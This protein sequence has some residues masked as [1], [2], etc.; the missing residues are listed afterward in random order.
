MLDESCI[1]LSLKQVDSVAHRIKREELHEVLAKKN[2][3]QSIVLSVYEVEEGRLRTTQKYIY[4]LY[5]QMT[6]GFLK[7][8]KATTYVVTW[9]TSSHFYSK[10]MI[11]RHLSWK[12]FRTVDST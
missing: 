9:A 7:G 1:G 4:N 11:I 5:C 10:Y 12:I 6:T 8:L 2:L 3:K